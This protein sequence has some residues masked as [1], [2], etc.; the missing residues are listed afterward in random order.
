MEL[1]AEIAAKKPLAGAL[2]VWWLGQSGFLIKSPRGSLLIDPYLSDSLTRKYANTNRPHVRMTTLAINPAQLCP[3]DLV[4]CSHK[5]SDHMDP[6]TLNPLLA[7]NRN[8]RV[9][10]PAALCEHAA[11]IGIE[12]SLQIPV[13]N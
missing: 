13:E 12:P 6:E 5:H 7:A 4:L 3:I 9:G 8:A 11:S 1:A 10:F 2:A